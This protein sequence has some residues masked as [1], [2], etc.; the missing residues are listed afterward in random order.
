MHFK[1]FGRGNVTPP[2]VSSNSLIMMCVIDAHERHDVFIVDIPGAYLITNIDEYILM[3]LCGKLAE[4]IVHVDPNLY[5][6]CVTTFL[7]R[8]PIL[9]LYEV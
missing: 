8:F 6:K 1:G 3:C 7:K 5:H 9:H 2:T 4:M